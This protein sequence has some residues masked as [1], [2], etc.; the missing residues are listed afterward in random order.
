MSEKPASDPKDPRFR[1]FRTAAWAVYLVVAVGFSS[2]IIYSVFS[3]VF[4]MTPGRPTGITDIMTEKD[5]AIEARALLADLDEHRKA[6]FADKDTRTADQRFLPFRND[7]LRRKKLLEARCAIDAKERAALRDMFATL[8]QVLDL[9]T[10]STVQFAGGVGPAL[11]SLK[12]QLDAI[13]KR[14]P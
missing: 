2:L 13:E 9:Y 3:S 4:R 14:Q 7:L 5:C 1:P 10:T 6:L 12:E 8:D 11:D